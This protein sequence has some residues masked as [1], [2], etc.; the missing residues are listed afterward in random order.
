ME[1][2]NF[3]VYLSDY[4]F[5][6]YITVMQ[7]LNKIVKHNYFRTI[8]PFLQAVKLLPLI[9]VANKSYVKFGKLKQNSR[10]VC[11]QQ[12][13]TD[14]RS[15]DTFQVHHFMATSRLAKEIR[16]LPYRLQHPFD[17]LKV[18]STVICFD[19]KHFQSHSIRFV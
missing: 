6:S 8:A 18:P 16:P 13:V 11:Q 12:A 1:W 14:E 15:F 2:R 19:F 3:S 4:S 10:K 9:I 7:P 17:L 5:Y